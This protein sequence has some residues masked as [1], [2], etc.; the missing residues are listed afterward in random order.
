MKNKITNITGFIIWGFAIYELI[1]K[2]V[3]ITLF[4]TLIVIGGALFLF[5]NATLKGLLKDFIKKKI[6]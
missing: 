6:E 5:E 1:K 3:N 4:V 2:E